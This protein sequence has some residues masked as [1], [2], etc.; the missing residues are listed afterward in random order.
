M[1][2]GVGTR[3][4]HILAVRQSTLL[5]RWPYGTRRS[6]LWLQQ[7]TWPGPHIS[8]A[9]CLWAPEQLFCDVASLEP[10]TLHPC[11]RDLTEVDESTC[12]F[13]F[14]FLSWGRTAFSTIIPF[15]MTF[16]KGSTVQQASQ[17][18]GSRLIPPLEARGFDMWSLNVL[19]VSFKRLPPSILG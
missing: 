15:K 2:D 4:I 11:H 18:Q 17:R 19:F 6:R 7:V 14:M 10:Q 5:H 16:N 12:Y 8:R 3:L 9:V 1:A 13:P